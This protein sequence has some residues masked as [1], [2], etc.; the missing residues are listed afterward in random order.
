[1]ANTN[2]GTVTPGATFDPALITGFGTR[3]SNW[4]FTASVQHEILPRISLDVGWFRRIWQNFQV[5]DNLAVAAGDFDTF[6]LRALADSRLPNGGGQTLTG[7]RN[8]KVASFGRPAQN[9]N[10]TDTA[11]GSQLEQWNGV[12][13]TVNGRLQNGVTFQFGTST[14]RTTED[15]CEIRAAL[16]ELSLTDPMSR[17]R[18]V[19]P[20]NTEAK[21]YATYVIPGIDVQTSATYRNVRGP[22]ISANWTVTNAIIAS[23]STLGRNLSGGNL[24]VNLLEPNSMYGP[25]RNEL[26]LRFGKV[27]RFGRARSVVSL[28]IFNALNNDAILGYNNT[29][30]AT[31]PTPTSILNARLMKVSVNFDF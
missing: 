16:P 8:L 28:D 20:W 25:R 10:T 9:Y 13:V 26:D 11:F 1:M 22:G 15:N 2:F 30:N 19:E 27:L 31:W 7:L 21:G 14:G 18:T 5:T 23:N 3:P 4:E 24:T 29:L 6:D 12:D 17:C